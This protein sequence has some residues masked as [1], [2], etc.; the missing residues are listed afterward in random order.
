MRVPLRRA[1]QAL[2]NSG[3][4]KN[5][6]RVRWSSLAARRAPECLRNTSLPKKHLRSRQCLARDELQRQLGTVVGFKQKVELVYPSIERLCARWQTKLVF[7]F[8]RDLVAHTVSLLR[9][10]TM[11]ARLQR[12]GRVIRFETNHNNQSRTKRTRRWRQRGAHAMTNSGSQV[13]PPLTV[14]LPDFVEQYD[15]VLL[16]NRL[17]EYHYEQAP[18]RCA[19]RIDYQDLLDRPRDTLRTVL[20]HVN[21]TAEG[22]RWPL[23]ERIS[24]ST[25]RTLRDSVSNF[26]TLRLDIEKHLPELLPFVD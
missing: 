26:D 9:K 20:Q 24:K 22:M 17:L 21:G 3:F 11:I 16:H 18:P 15:E 12:Q 8:R 19:L 6:T 25:S 13:L 7:L 14:L 10:K 5:E 1:E 2:S 4:S 23:D